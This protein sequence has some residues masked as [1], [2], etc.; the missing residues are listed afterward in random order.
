MHTSG[1]GA[2]SNRRNSGGTQPGDARGGTDLR[3]FRERMQTMEQTE[4]RM[5]KEDGFKDEVF[6]IIP[7]EAFLGFCGASAGKGSVS[8]GCRVLSARGRAHYKERLHGTDSCIL[9]YCVEGSG[10]IE[11]EGK[12]FRIGQSDAFCIPRGM[13][14]RYYADAKDPWSILWVH[15]KGENLKYFPLDT[16][17]TVHMKSRQSD[18]RMMYLFGLLFR[19]LRKNYT[20]GNFIYISQVLSLILSE[21]YYREKNDEI[22]TQNRHVTMVVRYMYE[23]IARDL[24]LEDISREVR[25]SKSYLN[26]IFKKY[27]GRAP[28]DFFIRLRIGE[29]SKLLRQENS[30]VY[31]VSTQMGYTDPYYFSRIFRKITGMSPREYKN[32]SVGNLRDGTVR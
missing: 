6:I 12:T 20:L 11:V 13:A 14:H 3:T 10:T 28:I 29:A 27:A 26:V 22:T 4:G 9:I 30:R 2:E 1:A 5:R 31:E 17:R 8:Y 32:S 23:N 24:T 19:V 15:F 25:L 7:T 18:S 21:V 16:C